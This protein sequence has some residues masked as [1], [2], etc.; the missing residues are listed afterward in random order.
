MCSYISKN[1][2]LL[3]YVEILASIYLFHIIADSVGSDEKGHI[4]QKL[5]NVGT[6]YYSFILNHK[7]CIVR[8]NPKRTMNQMKTI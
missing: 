3:H 7:K 4:K 8:R 6:N 1:V 5:Q 2:L